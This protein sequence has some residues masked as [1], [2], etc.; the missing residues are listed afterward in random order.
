MGDL[1]GWFIILFVIF[2]YLMFVYDDES[3]WN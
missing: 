3:W 2:L 1:L